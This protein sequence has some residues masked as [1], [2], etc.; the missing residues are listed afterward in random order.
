MLDWSVNAAF[1]LSHPCP[2]T[3]LNIGATWLSWGLLAAWGSLAL[4]RLAV[5]LTS[6]RYAILGA[7]G[8]RQRPPKFPEK[9]F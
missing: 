3:L 8:T 7:L 6:P 5:V 9:N 1:R 4:F 2:F